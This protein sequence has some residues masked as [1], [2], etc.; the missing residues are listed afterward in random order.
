MGCPKGPGNLLIQ[1]GPHLELHQ[2]LL[3]TT[4]AQCRLVSQYG[5]FG[6]LAKKSVSPTTS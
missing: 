2:K 5:L 3:H 4:R 6:C 1:R